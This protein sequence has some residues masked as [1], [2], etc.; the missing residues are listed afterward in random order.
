MSP[1][2]AIKQLDVLLRAKYADIAFLPSGICSRT[3]QVPFKLGSALQ[4][5]LTLFVEVD[6]APTTGVAT[7]YGLPIHPIMPGNPARRS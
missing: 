5:I 1:E 7:G 6:M 2:D 4:Y 3:L